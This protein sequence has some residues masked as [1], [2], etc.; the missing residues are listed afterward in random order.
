ME[1]YQNLPTGS[2]AVP[3]EQTEGQVDARTDGRTRMIKPIIPVKTLRKHLKPDF[4]YVY[5]EYIDLELLPN[6]LFRILCFFLHCA[7]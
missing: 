1:F 2:R 6:Y 4:K 3:F 7:F 5:L